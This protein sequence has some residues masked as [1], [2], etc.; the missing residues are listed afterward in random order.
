MSLYTFVRDLFPILRWSEAQALRRA[1]TWSDRDLLAFAR[2]G[3]LDDPLVLAL[4]A[5]DASDPEITELVE[6]LAMRDTDGEPAH[7]SLVVDV[8]LALTRDVSSA[9]SEI[10]S[11]YASLEYPECLTIRGTVRTD[12]DLTIRGTVRTD[13]DLPARRGDSEQVRSTACSAWT[14]LERT[15]G[16][17]AASVGLWF[18]QTKSIPTLAW[19]SRKASH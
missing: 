1:G 9:L 11:L 16:S 12:Y 3:D 2:D 17:R 15:A 13:Y 14:L 8:A 19:R 4:A 10:E 18:P 7:V 5:C 6:P